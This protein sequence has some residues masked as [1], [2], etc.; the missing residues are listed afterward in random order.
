MLSVNQYW[1]IIT[2]G[3][4]PSASLAAAA[5]VA[6]AAAA[7]WY[8]TD[9]KSKAGLL[10]GQVAMQVLSTACSVLAVVCWAYPIRVDP[11]VSVES[12]LVV[13]TCA[14]SDMVVMLGAC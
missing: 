1:G 6:T 8:L 9:T 13:C 12:G 10:G 3:W 11:H 14:H 7:L 5:M 4:V 2:V